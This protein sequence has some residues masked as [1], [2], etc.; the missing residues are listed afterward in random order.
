VPLAVAA[1]V[2]GIFPQYLL[3]IINPFAKEFTET[4]LNVSPKP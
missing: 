4:I 2:F 3:D 1:V